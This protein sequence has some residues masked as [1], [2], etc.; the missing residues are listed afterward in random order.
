MNEISDA[1]VAGLLDGEGCIYIQHYKA[2]YY[3]AVVEIG[4]TEK[5]LPLLQRIQ[6]QYG[7]RI[8]NIWGATEKWQA[9]YHWALHSKK[10]AYFLRKVYPFLILKC[11]QAQL[12]IQLH[13]MIDA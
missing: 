7:G 1:Y 10:A 2:K 4:M 3:H 9:A 6:Q 12:C 5:A 13:E 11:Y 8:R